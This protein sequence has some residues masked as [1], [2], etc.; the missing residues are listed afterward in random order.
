MD[1][2]KKIYN[3]IESYNINMG[4]ANPKTKVKK[5]GIEGYGRF[6]VE[7]IKPGEVVAVLGGV[8]VSSKEYYRFR[9]HFDGKSGVL[10]AK[11]IYIE[12]GSK[13]PQLRGTMNHSCTPNCVIR[14]QIVIETLRAVFPEEELTLDYSTI[15]NDDCVVTEN[16]LCS[17]KRCRGYIT[18]KDW[19]SN[20]I[21]IQYK[22]C[23][24]YYIQKLINQGYNYNAELLG[25]TLID[26]N[27]SK[28]LNFDNHERQRSSV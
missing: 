19:L 3:F 13:D 16:C 17:T 12:Q 11:D 24:S 8:V 9:K 15:I 4:Q 25:L 20:E 21:Q 18:G 22:G 5:S 14:G 10:V 1:K 23:F 27:K 7:S 6:A 26:I 2:L 28:V